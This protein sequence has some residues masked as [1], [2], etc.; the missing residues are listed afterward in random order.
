[1]VFP[2]LDTEATNY[3][4]EIQNILGYFYIEDTTDYFA[5]EVTIDKINQYTAVAF[6]TIILLKNPINEIRYSIKS[7]MMNAVVEGRIVI[8]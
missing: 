8:E 3:I 2:Y 4:K 7:K 5:I 1:M 6:P